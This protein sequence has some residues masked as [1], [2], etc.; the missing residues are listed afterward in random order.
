MPDDSPVH[1]DDIPP[2]VRIILNTN[3]NFHKKR[4]LISLGHQGCSSSLFITSLHELCPICYFL[5]A[6]WTWIIEFFLFQQLALT[7][8]DVKVKGKEL[9]EEFNNTISIENSFQNTENEVAM[10]NEN[11]SQL[12]IPVITMSNENSSQTPVSDMPMKANNLGNPV[13]LSDAE[14]GVSL[15]T[16]FSDLEE[17]PPNKTPGKRAVAELDAIDFNS[18][19]FSPESAAKLAKNIPE[20]GSK[21]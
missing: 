2:V 1:L 19:D 15:T 5:S 20:G 8:G 4:K 12:P 10:S 11:L 9:L 18:L 6:S 13:F 17:T 7:A 14:V 3:M 16:Y 21:E